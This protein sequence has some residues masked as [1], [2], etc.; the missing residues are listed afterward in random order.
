MRIK[1]INFDTHFACLSKKAGKKPLKK[2]I[3]NYKQLI[4]IEKRA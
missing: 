3:S 4:E 2:K 1:P